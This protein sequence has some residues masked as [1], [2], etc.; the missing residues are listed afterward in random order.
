MVVSTSALALDALALVVT[1]GI[2]FLVWTFAHLVRES[3]SHD[4]KGQLFIA[5]RPR[6]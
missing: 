5:S 1:F 6:R 2:G 4:D 3:R